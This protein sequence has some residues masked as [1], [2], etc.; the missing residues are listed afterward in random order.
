[1]GVEQSVEVEVALQVI[2]VIVVVEDG[3]PLGCVL[4]MLRH[5]AR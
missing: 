5:V 1:M 3:Q 4:E 2:Q